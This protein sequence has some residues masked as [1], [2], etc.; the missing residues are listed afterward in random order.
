[1]SLEAPERTFSDDLYRF[2][3]PSLG[4][5]AVAERFH[6]R[7]DDVACELTITSSD[8]VSG[9]RFYRGRLLLIGPNSLRDVARQC[10][11]ATPDLDWRGIVSQIRDLSL[12][13][14]RSGAPL[15]DLRLVEVGDAPQFLVFPFLLDR[16]IS[17]VYGDGDAAKSVLALTLAVVVASGVEI[18][19]LKPERTGPVLY[20][21]W[22]DDETQH[23]RRLRAICDAHGLDVDSVPV[24]YQR[25]D[26]SMKETGREIKRK[27]GEKHAIAAIIDSAG[28][29]SG[30]DPMDAQAMIASLSAA[31]GLAMPVFVIHHLPKDAKGN[32]KKS[33]YGSVYARNEVRLAHLVESTAEEGEDETRCVYTCTKGNWTG[34]IPSTRLGFRF[35][36]E[37]VGANRQLVNLMVSAL[38]WRETTDIK[39][40]HQKWTIATF[41]RDSGGAV[42][43]KQISEG[44][45]ITEARA[46][47]VLNEEKEM[48]VSF[49]GTKDRTWGLRSDRE[50]DAYPMR[51]PPN[52]DTQQP[53]VPPAS[54]IEAGTY[55]STEEDSEEEVWKQAGF[56]H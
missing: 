47:T 17:M 8:P 20:L 31:R 23:A 6:E 38:D 33:P 5:E 29:A 3:W 2:Q 42:T 30:G 28:M 36:N 1:V 22:E 49:G 21:D 46:R 55:E 35:T 10:A 26:A 51:T 27:A 52:T 45:E 7:G 4:L 44:V 34:T 19:G 43:V 50:E 15:V 13:R 39:P 40:P 32:Q 11:E 56:T 18:A 9:G 54:S 25:M 37:G 12:D 53:Y 14:Y 48:F 16:V 41:I 24:F